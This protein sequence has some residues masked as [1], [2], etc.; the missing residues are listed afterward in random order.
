MKKQC[1]CQAMQSSGYSRLRGSDY[2]HKN[3]VLK[4]FDMTCRVQRMTVFEEARSTGR[5][6]FTAEAVRS[7]DNAGVLDPLVESMNVV[8][9]QAGVDSLRGDLFAFEHQASQ[10]RESRAFWQSIR[11]LDEIEFAEVEL[12]DN[13]KCDQAIDNAFEIALSAMKLASDENCIDGDDRTLLSAASNSAK[14]AVDGR[15]RRSMLL[16]DCVG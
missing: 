4:T 3:Q 5:L 1:Y 13:D 12:K 16:N 11:D 15:L 9:L 8:L 6:F 10:L 2:K 14:G 7:L